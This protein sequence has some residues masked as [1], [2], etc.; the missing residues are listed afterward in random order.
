MEEVQAVGEVHRA[1]AVR[2]EAFR[3]GHQAVHQ[4]GA[5]AHSVAEAGRGAEAHSAVEVNRVV[6]TTAVGPAEIPETH[7][8]VIHTTIIETDRV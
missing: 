2:R 3:A 6:L 1:A 8:L 7:F 5:E 4:A